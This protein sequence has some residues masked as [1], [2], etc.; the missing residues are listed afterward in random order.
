MQKRK[1]LEKLYDKA[2]NN[3]LC[4][5]ANCLMDRA[6]EG[7]LSEWVEAKEE[8]QLLE[9][10]VK[11]LPISKNEFQYVGT[12]DSLYCKFSKTKNEQF[13][14]SIIVSDRDENNRLFLIEYEAGKKILEAYNT[15]RHERHLEGKN[16]EII[17]TVSNL[18]QVVERWEWKVS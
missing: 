2:C 17:C 11:E 1:L 15:E 16:T 3:L 13:V 14:K 5:S 6:K 7:Y 10:M 8:C 12:I 4:Y 9:E 18:C